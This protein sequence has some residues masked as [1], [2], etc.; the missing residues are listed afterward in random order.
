MKETCVGGG[1]EGEG[2][3]CRK[4]VGGEGSV[5]GGGE[6]EG[7]LCRRREEGGLLVQV[8]GEVKELWEEGG[9]WWFL[10]EV[11]KV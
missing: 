1:R 2:N 3:L 5:E 9:F 4:R 6:G 10:G 8:E 11:K 7:N